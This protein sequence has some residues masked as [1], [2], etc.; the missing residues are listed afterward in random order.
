MMPAALG[1]AVPI[2]PF[3]ANRAFE[4]EMIVAMSAALERTC[5]ALGLKLRDDAATRL[6]ASKIIK[7]AQRGIADPATLSSTVLE[8]LKRE[9]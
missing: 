6:V 7:L 9:N 4:P 8:E 3:L 2:R 1:G 5:K